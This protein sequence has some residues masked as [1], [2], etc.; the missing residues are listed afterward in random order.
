[1]TQIT[2]TENLANSASS[3][4]F[5]IEKDILDLIL[6]KSELR[7]LSIFLTLRNLC[8]ELRKEP[9]DFFDIKF[10]FYNEQYTIELQRSMN[11]LFF[12]I[13]E[14]ELPDRTEKAAISGQ[15]AIY[16]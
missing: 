7:D 13:D 4:K 12:D 14:D 6:N 3:I 8:N 1:V 2:L 5:Y 9:E 11:A 15:S 10:N 16:R